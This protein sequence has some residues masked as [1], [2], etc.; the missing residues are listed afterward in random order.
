MKKYVPLIL[1]L[2]SLLSLGSSQSHFNRVNC[3]GNNNCD[4]KSRSLEAFIVEDSAPGNIITTNYGV[5]QSD[6]DNTLKAGERGPAL[7][8][9]IHFREKTMHFDHERIPERVVHARGFG[10]HGYFQVYSPLGNVTR[11][12]F[13]NDPSLKTP[14]FVRFSTV[15]G[16]KGSADTVRDVRGF[17][18]KFYTEEGNFD[19]VGNNIPVFFI[20]DA[21][22]FLDIIHAA[23]P[24]PHNQIPQARTAHDN[25][26]DI[27][28]LMPETTHM[29]MWT[30]SDRAI[31]RSFRMMQ[32]FGV[33]TYLL[34]NAEGKRTFV[35]FHWRPILGT[36]SLVWDEALKL[37]GVDPDFN[38]R[39]LW[40]AIEAGAFPEY[41][42]GLQLV[43]EADADKFDFDILDA[44]KIIPEELVP[45]KI[46]G[47][48]VLNRNVDNFFAEIEQAAFCT[49]HLVPGI[50]PSDDPLLQ[51][52]MFS[53]FDTQISRLGSPN[54]EEIPINKPLAPVTNNQRDGK[55]RQK[56]DRGTVNYFPNRFGCPAVAS[57]AQGGYTH[58]P[59]P[60]SG[61]KIRARGPK[62]AEHFNQARLFYNSLTQWEKD[63]LIAAAQFELSYV[64][65]M[66]VRQ[67]MVDRFNQI[68][69]TLA[70]LVAKAIGVTPPTQF[71][72]NATTI[73]SP[74]LS[75][76]MTTNTI[77]TRRIAFLV[78]PGYDTTQLRAIRA[79]LQA[80]GA[81]PFIIGQ[82]KGP[83]GTGDSANYTY[84]TT[85]SVQYDALVLVGGTQYSFLSAIG[86][87]VAF[88]KETFKHYK[89]I[90]AVNEGVD[91]LATM[92]FTGI[93]LA[94][95]GQ[96]VSS[97]GVVTTMSF[98]ASTFQ[99]GNGANLEFG[100]EAF[101]AIAAHRHYLRNVSSVPA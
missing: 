87:A 92:N 16:F 68:D 57:A 22:K 83:L 36:H 32:G 29:I 9:D 81:V 53:Y 1:F 96:S 61:V 86:E 28:S 34:A 31:P 47:K 27:V 11:A 17:A 69:F 88:V 99:I 30:L 79:G 42:L 56:I 66:T 4:A 43:E 45:V 21:I 38:R 59:T 51:G 33:N 14:V 73:T 52:R 25:F 54:F 84:F 67:K 24:E 85:K 100:R 78:G 94:T 12:K 93:S 44:T 64:E 95:S 80:N 10:A 82:N 89:A 72:G 37:Q 39:D 3:T 48:M 20:Q 46:V 97:E 40:D 19:L 55:F 6:T 77:I 50:E 71:A 13:L 8:E 90:I 70:V 74:A 26:W 62:F 101:D 15:I 65:D 7:L 91:F 18:T 5:K 60:V 58:A 41:E 75:Q 63:H 35:K 76:N 49:S 98:Q 2:F 23:K